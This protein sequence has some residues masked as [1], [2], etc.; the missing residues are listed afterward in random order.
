[1]M[2]QRK[3]LKTGLTLTDFI[4]YLHFNLN[5]TFFHPYH[6]KA[7]RSLLLSG[8]GI[9]WGL[10][11]FLLSSCNYLFMDEQKSD[12]AQNNFDLLWQIFDERY[13]Y[14][15]EKSV[16]WE[17][18]YHRYYP[19]K[20]MPDD[21]QFSRMASMLEE[22][23]DG[24][25]TIDNGTSFRT[26]SGWHTSY[27]VNFSSSLINFYMNQAICLNNCGTILSV[28][29]ESIGY[30]RCPSFSDKFNRDDLDNAMAKFKSVKGVIIDVRNNGGGLVSEA[31]M[32]ASRFTREKTHVGYVRYK[33]GKG[34]NDF[35]DYFARY[36][37]PDGAHP[38]YGKVAVLTNRKVYSAANLFVSIMSNLPQVRIIGDHTGGGGGVPISA[39]LYNGWTVKLSTNP[40]FDIN[41]RSIE[42]GIKPDQSI[43]LEKDTKIDNIIEAA[44]TWIL[45]N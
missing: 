44:K 12:N 4:Q 13:C 27:P 33:T 26:Y 41:K 16:D 29:P 17:E 31:Y 5:V 21:T 34:H 25:V 35:S 37:A 24:H 19:H 18:I 40:V 39:E 30:I 22:L 7:L 1:M 23:K 43:E 8:G 42:S 20:S 15:K 2:I 9:G 45:A 11:L 6:C 38:F 14:F 3:L 32:L 36:V 10:I 28:L